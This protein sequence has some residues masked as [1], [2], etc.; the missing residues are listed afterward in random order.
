[1]KYISQVIKAHSNRDYLQIPNALTGIFK[2]LSKTYIRRKGG[3]FLLTKIIAD[4]HGLIRNR[5]ACRVNGFR[6]Q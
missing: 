2:E 1:M 3:K 5:R 6:I 4:K